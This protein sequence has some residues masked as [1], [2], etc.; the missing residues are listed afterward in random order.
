[1]IMPIQKTE[2]ERITRTVKE[3]TGSSL[4]GSGIEPRVAIFPGSGEI[5]LFGEVTSCPVS[6]PG[7]P[8]DWCMVWIPAGDNEADLLETIE[9][10]AVDARLVLVHALTGFIIDRHGKVIKGDYFNLEG[11]PVSKEEAKKLPF[12]VLN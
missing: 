7:V 5:W 1:M 4:G 2:A 9:A 10:Y 6:G 12:G 11:D 8:G 3:K